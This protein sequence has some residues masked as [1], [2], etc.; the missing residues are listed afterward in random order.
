[1]TARKVRRLPL[2]TGATIYGQRRFALDLSL[3]EVE[4]V[5]GINRGFLSMIERGRMI[6]TQE[7]SNAL[8]DFY[9]QANDRTG[10]VTEG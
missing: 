7:E 8:L 2:K 6:P 9:A 3:R 1:M 10:D 4:Q 5:T